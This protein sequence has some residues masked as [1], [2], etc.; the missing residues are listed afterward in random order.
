MRFSEARSLPT[1][2]NRLRQ[3]RKRTNA[4]LAANGQRWYDPWILSCHPFSV[5]SACGVGFDMQLVPPVC[6]QPGMNLKLNEVPGSILAARG[7]R[8]A[9]VFCDIKRLGTGKG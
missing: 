7:F 9:G 2:G 3:L 8:A 6:K 5:F 1:V 4:S